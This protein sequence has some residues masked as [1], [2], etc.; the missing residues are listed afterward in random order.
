MVYQITFNIAIFCH[1]SINKSFRDFS[2]EIREYS[3]ILNVNFFRCNKPFLGSVSL[4]SN[5]PLCKDGNARFTTVLLKD[6]SDQ[7]SRLY[8]GV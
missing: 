4:I 1:F 8:P 6:L 2:V 5:N 7:V 3:K